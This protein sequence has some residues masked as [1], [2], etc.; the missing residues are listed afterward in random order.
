M[1]TGSRRR[2]VRALVLAVMPL[3]VFG[4]LG[5]ALALSTGTAGAVTTTIY[6]TAAHGSDA[7]TCST[8]APCKT[9]GHALAIA[10]A[11]TTIQLAAGTYKAA[12]DPS[13]TSNTVTTTGITIQGSAGK[14]T[15]TVVTGAG[16][17][18]ALAVNANGVTVQ[19]LAFEHAGQS[20]VIVSPSSSAT[21]PTS[22]TGVHIQKTLI[23]NN[24]LCSTTPTVA[25][26][27]KT[28]N[29]KTPTPFSDFGEGLHLMSV[30]TS[31]VSTNSV[32]GNYGGILVTDEL[33][34][35][36]NDT[37]SGNNASTNVGDC[38]ITLAGHNSS[39]VHTSGATT[40]KPSPATGGVYTITV[41]HNTADN[42][43][44]AGLLDAGGPPGT[45]V[46]HNTFTGNTAD[47]NGLSGFTLHSH[48]PLQ[49]MN[50]NVVTT[51]TFS[52]DAL[53]GLAGAPGDAEGPPAS[54]DMG[55]SAA[56]E[57]LGAIAPVTGTTIEHNH[58]TSVFYGVWLSP[59]E[60]A[61]S[62]I[63]TNPISVSAGGT[64]VFSE[65]PGN[66]GYWVAGADG[67]A[68]NFGDLASY[69]SATGAG[70]VGI[71]ASPDGGG[72]WVATSNGTVHAFG[73]AQNYG[74]APGQHIVVSNIVG[75]AATPD[76]GGYWLVGSDGGIFTFGDA[77]F[78][79]SMG[80]QHLNQPVVGMATTATGKGYW[81]VASDGGIFSF[82][83]TFHGS[84]GGQHLN[85]PVVGMAASPTGKGYWE[86]A[87]DGGIFSFGVT[88]HGSKGS[89]HLNQPIVGM[90]VTP[91]GGGYWL[92]AKDGGI[93]TFGTAS[94]QGSVPGRAT[95]T[96]VVG[97]ATNA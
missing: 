59:H 47:G 70:V 17:M 32:T 81:E 2:S 93:F 60:T 18:N 53:H 65:P 51:N 13:G 12:A 96:D 36:H 6:L 92:V 20:G 84:K 76:G 37:I 63:A 58:I 40:G 55:Q 46:Y 27:T 8:A 25:A 94:F 30:A 23:A 44:A 7:N 9:L 21:P 35:T 90:A 34:P 43:G 67:S 15:T 24:D 19:Y 61:A 49:D 95:V 22:I 16:A 10:T 82:G 83:V 75:I 62:I 45:G 87:S 29:C 85:Q 52:A 88:F 5:G 3:A 48:A 4:G 14:T 41:S 91:T 39:A 79:G 56:I 97:M 66:G 11:G 64:A 72:Y 80:G 38:G 31:V 71:A 54:A 50:T 1:R 68:Y 78:H 28:T 77:I 73:D 86:V 42:N 89:Q 57:I 26:A 33:G 69:G 74:T